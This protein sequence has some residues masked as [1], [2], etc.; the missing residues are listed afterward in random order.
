[1]SYKRVDGSLLK[2]AFLRAAYVLRQNKKVVDALNVFPVP[3]GD[4]GTNMSLTMDQA[5]EELQ[6][7]QSDELKKVVDAVAWGSLMGARGNSGVILSQ[8]FRGFSQSISA[9]KQ[10]I[11]S[12]EFAQAFKNGVDSA[13]RAVMRPVEGTILTVAREMADKMLVDSRKIDDIEKV[14]SDALSYSEKILAKTP[15]MLKVLKEAKVVDAGGKGLIYLMQGFLEAFENPDIITSVAGQK[16][17]RSD[18]FEFNDEE[19][20]IKFTYCT[21]LFVRGRDIDLDLLKKQLSELGDSIIVTGMDDIVKIHIHSNHPGQVMETALKWGELSNIK[22][23]NMKIQHREL[24]KEQTKDVSYNV[25]NLPR[26]EN[27]EKKTGIVAVSQG[28]GLKDIFIS[29]GADDVIEGG[30]TMNPSTEN[31]LS[32]IEKEPFENVIILPNNKN[33]IMTAEQVKLI[34]KKN[35][36]VLP[37]RSVPQGIAALLAFNP[38]LSI[39]DN[40]AGMSQNIKNVVTG[41]VTYAVRDSQWN[42]TSIKE[43][44]VIGLKDGQLAVVEKD[45]EKVLMVLIDEM[46]RGR[47]S[48]IITIYYGQGVDASSMQDI[49]AELSAK[50]ANFDVESYEGGQSLYFYIVS[51][52]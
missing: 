40:L 45:K 16:E 17:E 24:I 38:M 43:G 52:E 11:S 31:I 6:K 18:A 13:Y 46:V 1:M 2:K 50:Y 28:Q 23:D 34:S 51:V 20:T 37:T 42:G 5:S 49:S 27:I 22:V 26:A 36:Y 33:I 14:L 8:L 9:S 30:Q 48:G 10:S 35:I 25:E 39:E 41:E 47:E 3:D 44:D 19:N 12:L 15:E 7:L 21:E 4:T 29:L 32:A